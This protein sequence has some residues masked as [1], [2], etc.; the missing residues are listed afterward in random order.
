MSKIKTKLPIVIKN[1]EQQA[2]IVYVEITSWNYNKGLN[3]TATVRDF[4]ESD[5]PSGTPVGTIGGL[6][7]LNSKSKS[8]TIEQINALFI[9]IDASIPEDI[10]YTEKMDSLLAQS[11]L[12]ITQSELDEN[13]KTIYGLLPSDWEL[14]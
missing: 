5:A 7:T 2:A 8:Y 14:A 3:Y 9:E 13:G 11:L 6:N 12:Y 10:N 1:R 4:Y